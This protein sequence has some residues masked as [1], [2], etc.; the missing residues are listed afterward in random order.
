MLL[1]RFEINERREHGSSS[2][3]QTWEYYVVETDGT[4][5]W[6]HAFGAPESGRGVCVTRHGL[7]FINLGHLHDKFVTAVQAEILTGIDRM[8]AL[9]YLTELF[10]AAH[11]PFKD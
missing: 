1:Y 6:E 11:N 4:L 8:V 9:D 2:V 3:C 5:C 7:R 10:H